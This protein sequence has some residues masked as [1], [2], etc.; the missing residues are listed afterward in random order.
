MASYYLELRKNIL[1][2]HCVHKLNC[3]LLTTPEKELLLGDFTAYESALMHA[4]W[5]F[6]DWDIEICKCCIEHE[7]KMQ[8]AG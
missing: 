5:H 1:D 2:E 8:K 7:S 6:P 3:E 4:K